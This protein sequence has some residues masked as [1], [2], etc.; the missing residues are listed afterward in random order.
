M[1]E[2][3][4]DILVVDDQ[5]DVVDV[6]R[7]GLQQ[8]GHTVHSALSGEEGLARASTESFDAIVLDVMLP[9]MNGFE[10]ARELRDRG[11]TTPILMLTAKDEEPDVV[12]GLSH[13]AD[14]YL[15]KPFRIGEL[16]AHLMALK[17]RVGMEARTVLRLHDVELDRVKRE[18]RR[19]GREISLTNI[20]FKLLETLMLRPDRIFSKEELLHMVW[21][22]TFDPG[23]GVLNVHLGNLRGKLEREGEPRLIQTVRGRGYCIVKD[24]TE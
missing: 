21:G 10:V 9:G 8:A 6:I 14:A 15:P 3:P 7:S 12:E 23:T 13:G 16:E 2:L 4:L 1:A 11:V 24:L 18:V 19:G 5:P 20:E 22:L 17:R